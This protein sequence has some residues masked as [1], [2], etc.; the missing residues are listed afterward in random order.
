MIQFQELYTGCH[1]GTQDLSSD[2]GTKVKAVSVKFIYTQICR[3]VIS[4]LDQKEKMNKMKDK[5]NYNKLRKH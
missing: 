2:N 4:T 1:K 3:T 5:T